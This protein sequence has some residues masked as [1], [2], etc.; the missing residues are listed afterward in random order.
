MKN[1]L[2]GI[3]HLIML[4]LILL[5]LTSSCKKDKQN[6]VTDIDGNVYHTVTIG[7]QTWMVENLRVTRFNNNTEIPYDNSGQF[8]TS[9]YSWFDNDSQ[10][11]KEIYGALYNWHA[12][13]TGKLAP[14]GWRVA[15]KKDYDDLITFLGEADVAAKK[16]KEAGTEHWKPE[17]LGATNSSGFTALPGGYLAAN[18]VFNKMVDSGNGT[19]ISIGCYWT[20]D[21]F[22]AT[23]AFNLIIASDNQ[24]TSSF[25]EFKS[26]GNSVRCIKGDP[27]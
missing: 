27:Q 4:V 11:Y 2:K 22:D 20:S 15:T 21:E 8:A 5:N 19:F 23:K 24:I 13:K 25:K 14:A 16:L 3:G 10:K 26:I 1:N 9:S 6:T 7:T 18:G 17:N 12:V